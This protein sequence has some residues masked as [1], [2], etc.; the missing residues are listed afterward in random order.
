MTYFCVGTPINK[1]TQI[2]MSR[3]ICLILSLLFCG[4]IV[5]NAQPFINDINAFKKKDAESFPP[6]NAILFIGSSSFTKWKDVQDWFP[7]YAIIN[8]G[9]GGSSLPDVIRY[10]NDMVFP[11][12]PSQV[13]IYCGE[14]DLAGGAGADT[15]TQRFQKLFYL[16]R[17]KLPK[18][19]IAFVAMKAS[20][21]RKQIFADLVKANESIKLFL[22]THKKT[23]FIDVY[24]EMLQPNGYP[25]GEVFLSDSLHMNAAGY[26]IWQ[27]LIQPHLVKSRK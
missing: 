9:F 24:T 14:N 10:A 17:N 20:P 15:V 19:P 12:E 2:A 27:M 1:E 13:V 6:K 7:G 22:S 5:S 11:Y 16:I 25:I 3:K 18:V 8:R 23:A 21:S 26:R 4:M